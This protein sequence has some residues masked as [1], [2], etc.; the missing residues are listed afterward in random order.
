MRRMA[1]MMVVTGV[2]VALSGL[3]A[4]PGQ[5]QDPAAAD[6]FEH[7]GMVQGAEWSADGRHVWVW[8]EE[9]VYDWNLDDI[10]ESVRLGTGQRLARVELSRDGSRLM[11]MSDAGQIVIWDALAHEPLFEIPEPSQFLDWSADGERIL[12]TSAAPSPDN[13]YR[14]WDVATET[15]LR[16]IPSDFTAQMSPNGAWALTVGEFGLMIYGVDEGERIVMGGGIYLVPEDWGWNR[17][18]SALAVVRSGGFVSV[19]DAPEFTIRFELIVE[20]PTGSRF[21]VGWAADDTLVWGQVT[22]TSIH[23]WDATTGD[24]LLYVRA[25]GMI[26]RVDWHGSQMAISFLAA[27]GQ[28]QVYDAMTGELT[29]DL[30]LGFYYMDAVWSGD[31]RYLAARFVEGDAAILHADSGVELYRLPFPPGP[32]PV[33]S[34]VGARFLVT[35]GEYVTVYDV[36]RVPGLAAIEAAVDAGCLGC[37]AVDGMAAPLSEAADSDADELRAVLRDPDSYLTDA[38][39]PGVQAHRHLAESLTDEQMDLILEY[40]LSL[41]A[42]E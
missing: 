24:E 41:G 34:P 3:L 32:P 7:D 40:I 16:E 36:A 33:W 29:L 21:A 30:D 15:M 28:L 19:Y 35:E 10:S 20:P 5:A 25:V 38:P 8:T 27:N 14:V 22:P 12:T 13:P 4:V 23:I 26:D 31:G 39:M 1:M 42:M 6:V 18:G 37:H 2:M 17:D 9:T 11:T